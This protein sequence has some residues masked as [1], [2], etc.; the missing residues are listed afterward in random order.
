MGALDQKLSGEGIL[1]SLWHEETIRAEDVPQADLIAMKHQYRME[2]TPS[3]DDEAWTFVRFT[4]Q[5]ASS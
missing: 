4:A 2:A 3:A 5:E 1:R